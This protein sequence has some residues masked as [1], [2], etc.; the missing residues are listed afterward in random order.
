MKTIT[1]NPL[2]LLSC[3]L[4]LLPLPLHSAAIAI[5]FNVPNTRG[6]GDAPDPTL[7]DFTSADPNVAGGTLLNSGSGGNGSG[8][9]DLAVSTS[10]G[11]FS[12]ITT[13]SANG[14]N[15]GDTKWN[16][17]DPLYE[18]Y[19]YQNNAD[20]TN[21]MTIS[22][23]AAFGAGQTI[24]LT[25]HGVGDSNGQDTTFIASYGSQ[26]D[27]SG[28][29]TMNASDRSASTPFVQFSFLSDGITDEISYQFNNGPGGTGYHNGLSLSVIP[30][31]STALLGALGLF[32]LLRRRR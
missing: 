31:P 17:E 15:A 27:Q 18:G 6:D 22:G 8:W 7:A 2:S 29:T 14:F 32:G 21:V 1:H 30:E 3:G 26:P 9:T 25:L 23:L 12:V 19:V 28:T 24:T 10:V 11:P 16:D 20:G 13:G 5:N 4:L